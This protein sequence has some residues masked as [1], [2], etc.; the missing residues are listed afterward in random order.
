MDRPPA[1]VGMSLWSDAHQE[2]WSA[3]DRECAAALQAREED[4]DRVP[5]HCGGT[6]YRFDVPNADGKRP[7]FQP[8]WEPGGR[9]RDMRP[10]ACPFHSTPRRAPRP[11]QPEAD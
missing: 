11:T 9:W 2:W 8:R 5:L 3:R 4:L 6:L 10:L 7:P 1:L